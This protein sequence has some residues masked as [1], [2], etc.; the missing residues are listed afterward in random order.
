M[1]CMNCQATFPDGKLPCPEC[2]QAVPRDW[3]VLTTVY[4]PEDSLLKGLLES[5]GIPVLLKSEAIGRIEAFSF[6]PLAE[7]RILVPIEKCEEAQ[8]IMNQEYTDEQ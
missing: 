8:E 1:L 3:K 5:C 6:G 4:P 2:G 7:V